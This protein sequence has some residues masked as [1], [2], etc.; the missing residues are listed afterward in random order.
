MTIVAQ[1]VALVRPATAPLPV[2][3]YV[4]TAPLG[5]VRSV[6]WE[7]YPSPFSSSSRSVAAVDSL[8]YVSV[9]SPART[10]LCVNVRTCLRTP[11]LPTYI[12]PSSYVLPPLPLPVLLR[13]LPAGLSG[14][15]RVGR[16]VVHIA[17]Y[18]FRSCRTIRRQNKR[19]VG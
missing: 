11:S 14:L 13:I 10:R 19:A 1:A 2:L 7:T 16:S 3:Y 4:Y 18:S 5:N 9:S 6:V 17:P 8:P 12:A 15:G